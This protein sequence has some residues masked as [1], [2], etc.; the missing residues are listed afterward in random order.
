M[1]ALPVAGI[2][3]TASTAAVNG[4]MTKRLERGEFKSVRAAAK[5]AG[6]VKDKSQKARKNMRLNYRFPSR[7]LLKNL[8]R[9]QRV[10]GS[11]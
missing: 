1:E 7:I 8:S 6:I 5:A 10:L 2:P 3:A 4:G 11:E 9:L